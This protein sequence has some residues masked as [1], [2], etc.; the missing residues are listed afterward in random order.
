[1][2]RTKWALLTAMTLALASPLRAA[3]ESPT[4]HWKILI[5]GRDGTQVFWLVKLQNAESK[6]TGKLIATNEQLPETTMS[7]VKAADGLLRFT[8]K[9]GDSILQFEGKAPEKDAKKFAGTLKQGSG[10][11]PVELERTALTKIDPFEL[12]KEELA[13]KTGGI[14]IINSATLLLQQAREKKAKPEEVRSWAAKAAKAAE[15]F[16]PRWER[17]ISLRLAEILAEEADYAT[18]ALD[19][20]RKAERF[21]DAKDK[22]SIQKR[23]LELLAK[24]LKAAKK[25]DDAKD[26]E[27]RIKKIPTDVKPV[28]FTGRKEKSDRVVLVELFTGAECPPCVAADKAFDALGETY[29]PSEVVL[30]QYHLH[31]PKPDP[32]TSPD[33]LERARYY[34]GAIRGT[35]TLMVNGKPGPTV[36]G[37]AYEAAEGYDDFRSALDPQLEVASKAALKAS[38]TRK[39]NKI[40][41]TA[42]ASELKDPGD[43]IKLR[44]VLVED[45]VSY[46]GGNGIPQHHSVVRALPGGVAGLAL[47]EKAGKQT[48]TVDTEDL[49]KELKKYLDD[50]AEKED[51]F[52]NKERPMELKK[53]RVVAFVQNDAT[54]EIYQAVQVDVKDE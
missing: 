17:E 10:L 23:T 45:V 25:D 9:F 19:Y 5:S 53:L 41:I 11:V 22:P 54:R 31:I 6:W 24:S 12:A 36:G 2:A 28:V 18:T 13:T 40:S 7:D 44:M 20:A 27:A 15:G 34:G 8:L 52:P 42:E 33:G 29:K 46:K 48:A 30:L 50:Y 1:M 51:A 43:R 16:G 47:K 39:G 14:E 3:D 38:A 26:V 37:D 21:L 32:L 4:D 35:P 49:K